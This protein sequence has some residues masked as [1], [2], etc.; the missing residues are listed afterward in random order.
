MIL[1]IEQKRPKRYDLHAIVLIFVVVSLLI[2]N[3]N[4]SR[5]AFNFYG[6]TENKEL[7]IRLPHDVAI[8]EV[9]V[10]QGVKV[11]KGDKRRH[12]KLKNGLKRVGMWK[13]SFKLQQC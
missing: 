13:P 6:L 7:K 4:L 9:L 5:E 10:S 3:I 8:E 12:L 11:R 2:I 1:I